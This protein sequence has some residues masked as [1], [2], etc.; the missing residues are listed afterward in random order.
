MMRASK[1]LSLVLIGLLIYG[2]NEKISPE[3]QSGS[4]T[5]TP[6]PTATPTYT[7]GVS[8][9]NLVAVGYNLHKTGSGNWNKTCEISTT[10]P[11]SSDNFIAD[12]TSYDISCFFE[13]E[14]LALYLTGLS[15]EISANANACEHVGYT[16]Y[17]F[18]NFMAGDSTSTVTLIECD[19]NVTNVL[20]QAQPS[21]PS[22]GPGTKATCDQ[23]VDETISTVSERK[24]RT[25][26]D[27]DIIFCD[28]NYTNRS[29]AGEDGPNCDVGNVMVNV[30]SYTVPDPLTAPAVVEEKSSTRRVT[31]GGLISNC[32]QGPIKQLAS[33]AS[34]STT[35]TEIATV[36]TGE[37]YSK[38]HELKPLVDDQ[39]RSTMEYANYRRHMASN[40]IDFIDSSDPLDT[41][42]KQSFSDEFTNKTFNPE[43]LS[44]YSN[45]LTM[46]DPFASLVTTTDINNFVLT[47]GYRTRPISAEPFIGV[48]TSTHYAKVNPFYTFY[49]FDS[50]WEVKAR[51][52]MMVRDWDRINVPSANMELL[53]DIQLHTTLATHYAKQDVPGALQVP[54]DPD[55]YNGYNDIGDWD[56]NLVM[57]RTVGSYDSAT[58]VWEPINGF[59]DLD[60]FPKNSF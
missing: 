19:D 25:Y 23:I 58:T 33:L 46:A 32:V 51:I 49:C 9:S 4:T 3:L 15:F 44:R 26:T 57:L 20:A 53:S 29:F 7:F 6:T 45:N 60:N 11:M 17:S 34:S 47:K 5:T 12:P 1:K 55:G 56:D 43:I 35:F 10:V 38:I 36:N 48:N 28:Y 59:F 8:N 27:D 54:T 21:S 13:A 40:D 50:A 14:E 37:S 30:I 24:V 52:R 16:P 18:Y 2:C 22:Y 31:C 42:Y 41:T 39:R